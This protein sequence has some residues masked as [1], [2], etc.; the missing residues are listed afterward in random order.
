M[1]PIYSATSYLD[2]LVSEKE[3]YKKLADEMEKTYAELAVF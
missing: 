3:K 1:H 2:N